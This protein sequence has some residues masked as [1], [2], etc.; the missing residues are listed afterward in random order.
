MRSDRQLI[1]LYQGG[2]EAAFREFYSRHRRVIFVYLLALVGNRASAEE[3]LQET[4][5]SFLVH[6]DR[7][8][9]SVD[10][11]PYLLR[12]ARNRAIDHL[13]R[14]RRGEEAHRVRAEDALLNA[15]SSS[16][17]MTPGVDPEELSD[18][19]Q[20]LPREQRE[21]I[22]LKVFAGLTFREIAR[23]GGCPEGS[24]VSRYRY[25]LEK[26]RAMMLRGVI[27]DRNDR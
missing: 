20:R 12:I 19:L 5:F 6:L 2:D 14:T 11:R 7:L 18:C 26:L 15:R 8:N 4:Y 3:L 23:H 10:L 16:R 24:A 1:G 17:G 13:R 25:G 27:D 22:V 21:V 9:G